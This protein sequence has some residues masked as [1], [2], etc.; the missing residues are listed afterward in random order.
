MVV[1]ALALTGALFASYLAGIDSSE[2]EVTKYQYLADVSGQFSYD[3]TPT[4]V[5]FDPSSNYVGYYSSYTEDYFPVDELGYELNNRVN[6]YR[7]NLPPIDVVMDDNKNVSVITEQNIPD[8]NGKLAW[9]TYYTE[10]Y[11]T[12]QTGRYAMVAKT[13]T[14][15]QL[16]SQFEYGDYDRIEIASTNGNDVN[17]SGASSSNPISTGWV[18][19]FPKSW[20]S[21]SGGFEYRYTLNVS[22]KEVYD[23]FEWPSSVSNQ[24]RMGKLSL[25]CVIDMKTSTVILYWDNEFQDRIGTFNLSDVCMAYSESTSSMITPSLKL[26]NVADIVL[27][28]LPPAEYLDPNYGVTMKDEE[29]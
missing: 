4:Y 13:T 8:T 6:N 16:I 10:P 21:D 26:S 11:S 9:I 3:K 25:S 7:I 28:V 5:D 1:V 18:L 29:P 17:V 14:L 27:E 22:Q 15:T 12:D 20:V 24:V 23:V 19:F 2:Y